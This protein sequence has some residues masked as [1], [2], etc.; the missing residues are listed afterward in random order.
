MK[1]L[2][3]TTSLLLITV[4][5]LA[6]N[7]K[8]AKESKLE[9]V[10]TAKLG[11]AKINQS[12]FVSLNANSNAGDLLLSYKLGKNWGLS[13]GVSLMEL[14]TNLTLNGATASLQNSYL[15]IPLKI[16]GDYVMFNMDQSNSKVFF[17]V[18]AGFYA[19]TLLKSELET[20]TGNSTTKN[21]GWN[22][23]I[24]FNTGV[25]FL[26]SDKTSIGIGFEGQGDL[27]KMKKDGVER[28]VEQLNSI[29]FSFGFKF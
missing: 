20:L 27:S 23:G 26:I 19:S 29:Y 8:E 2:L 21:L 15:Q 4:V 1:K 10:A 13:S 24:V 11:W 3:L 18:G 7:T 28:K 9:F 22:Y 16:G 5:C 17:N 25:K 14:N 12:G 6:Q